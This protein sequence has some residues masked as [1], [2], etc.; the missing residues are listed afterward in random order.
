MIKS[1]GSL[2]LTISPRLLV[3]G[4]IRA[5]SAAVI[6]RR[7]HIAA[8][9]LQAAIRLTPARFS[10]NLCLIRCVTLLQFQSLPAS[11]SY[12]APN[13]VTLVT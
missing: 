8:L 10:F 1:L 5:S 2:L 12:P 7:I 11:P 6:I 4:L 13:S 3:G 9:Q